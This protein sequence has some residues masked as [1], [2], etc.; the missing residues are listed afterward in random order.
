MLD[1]NIEAGDEKSFKLLER[2]DILIPFIQSAVIVPPA[3]KE[4]VAIISQFWD[5]PVIEPLIK[6]I[7]LLL[8]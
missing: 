7:P 8:K 3:R 2:V 6:N 1:D 5:D 4:I